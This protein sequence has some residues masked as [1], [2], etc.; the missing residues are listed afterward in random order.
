[1][2][3]YH[4]PQLG[5]NRARHFAIESDPLTLPTFAFLPFNQIRIV[6]AENRRRR[7]SPP[8]ARFR[9]SDLCESNLESHWLAGSPAAARL[10]SANLF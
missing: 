5:Q 3:S 6:L 4:V 8:T 10:Q 2:E 9:L 7:N 1:M